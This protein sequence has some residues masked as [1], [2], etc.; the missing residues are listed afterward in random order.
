[1]SQLW[2]CFDYFFRFML[3]EFTYCLVRLWVLVLTFVLLF[4]YSLYYML[5]SRPVVVSRNLLLCGVT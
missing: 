1:M 2:K 4:N 5:F 3:L